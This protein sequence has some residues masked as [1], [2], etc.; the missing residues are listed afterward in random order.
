MINTLYYGDNLDVLRK[1][2]PDASVDLIYLD[3]PFNSNRNYNVLFKEKSGDASPAQI[4][5]FNDTW[6]WDRAAEKTYDELI[7]EGPANVS[8]MIGA[9]R[10]FIGSNDMMAYLVM[11]A[12]R[13]G[14]LHR[15]LKPTGSLYLHCDPTASHYLKI[16]MDSI[17][18][19]ERF[20]SEISWKRTSAHSD[21]AQGR[22]NYGHIRDVIL[23]YCK[24][25]D[26]SWQVQHTPY[27]EGYVEQFYRHVEPGTGR[28][29]QSDNLTAAKPGGDTSYE[30]K[31]VTPYKGRFW[32]YSRAKMDEFERQDRLVYTKSGM[33]RYKR[34]LDEM[35]GVALQDDW[36]DIPP[37]SGRERLGYPTQKPLSLLERIINASSNP[38][39]IVLDPFCGCGTAVV[40]AQKLG[41]QWIGI[42]VTH[43]AISL[44][45]YR[46][47]DSFPGIE[48]EVK[49]EPADAGSATMLAEADRYQF[50]WWALSLVKAKPVEGKEKKGADKGID[51]V[52]VFVDDASQKPKRC[53]VQ[54]KSGH[55]SSATIRDLVGALQR[56]GAE[57]ALL[58]TL[59][60][61]SGPMQQEA[62][63]A[64]FYDSVGWGRQFPKVQIITIEELMAGKKPDLPPARQTFQQAPVIGEGAKQHAMVFGAGQDGGQ[65]LE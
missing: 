8:Q 36:D 19:P 23:Y 39:D 52:I 11:M 6:T 18:G 56:E 27:D 31:G 35:L 1:Y 42:D 43:L 28:R 25:K 13:L 51:G 40:A 47:Q 7:H 3:P 49:G 33:P 30:W 44:I 62:V 26:Y 22:R 29:Y 2:V 64:G 50:Q 9:L 14:E 54:V 57:L 5:A 16:V 32:A 46:L 58:V 63:T 55:V 48:F 41:R 61:S 38:G 21:A 12:A 65:D 10:Q 53:L 20:M 45:K 59:E 24:S 15:V 37:A 60:P 34:Y 17:F 4:E